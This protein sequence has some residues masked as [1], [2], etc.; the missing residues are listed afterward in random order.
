MTELNIPDTWQSLNRSSQSKTS[1]VQMT[2]L[3]EELLAPFDYKSDGRSNFDPYEIPS[4]PKDFSIGLIVGA[5]G[6]GKSTLLSEFGMTEKHDWTNNSIA[7]HFDSADEA[8]AKFYAV[9]L[10]SVPSWVKPY[11]VLSN[12]EKFRAN[13]ARSLK[14]NA[15][16]DEFTSVVDRNIAQAASKTFAKY[17]RSNNLKGVVVASCH[18]D[19]IAMLEPDW[20]IDTDAAQYVIEPKECLRRKEMVAQVYEVQR[21]AWNYFAAHH[22]LTAKL[23]PFAR[24][25]ISVI[26]DEPAAFVGAISYPSGTLQNAFRES[27]LVTH[28]DFQGFGL[29]PRMSEFVANAYVGIGK[30]Y[31]SKTAHPRLGQWRENSKAW[32]P[33]SKNKKFRLDAQKDLERKAKRNRFTSWTLNPN[34]FVYSHEYIGD[35][36]EAG[37]ELSTPDL[38]TDN[39]TIGGISILSETGSNK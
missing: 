12:G 25:F 18:R 11:S 29:G 6:S 28:P 5:S 38:Q 8:A 27:R 13:L 22:Y 20:I 4:L 21:T 19:I 16:I 24:C 35:R 23:S 14:P 3:L 1:S 7:D 32:K 30:R 2:K 9:G 10:S 39:E 36:I 37:R 17:I 26:G 34:R 33:T 15:V 31:F